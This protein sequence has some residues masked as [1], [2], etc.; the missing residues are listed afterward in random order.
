[1][2]AATVPHVSTEVCNRWPRCP[3]CAC[4]PPEAAERPHSALLP[5]SSDT[6]ALKLAEATRA[7]PVLE[8]SRADCLILQ[9]NAQMHRVVSN[10]DAATEG[11]RMSGM[12]AIEL[13]D[14]KVR[15]SCRNRF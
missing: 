3:R 4:A 2:A 9:E 15:A 8:G 11:R 14:P 13:L 10:C 12:M 6:Q 7:L 5:V 1:M